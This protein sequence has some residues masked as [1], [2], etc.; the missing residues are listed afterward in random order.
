[1]SLHRIEPQ[2][3][4]FTLRAFLKTEKLDLSQAEA[5]ADLIASDNEGQPTKIA[6]HKLR[7]GSSNE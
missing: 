6:I 2:Q 7:G 3:G 5:V 4:E 1:M